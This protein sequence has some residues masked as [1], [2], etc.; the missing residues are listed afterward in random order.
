MFSPYQNL[1][2]DHHGEPHLSDDH[3][4]TCQLYQGQACSQYLTGQRVH[5][6]SND[7]ETIHKIDRIVLDASRVISNSS[8]VSVPCKRYAEKAFCFHN[9]EICDPQ[10]SA[11]VAKD[12]TVLKICKHDCS[13]VEKDLCPEEYSKARSQDLVGHG[14]LLPDCGEL[15]DHVTK[16]A[17]LLGDFDELP[18]DDPCYA[19]NGVGY[20]GTV[21]I[22]EHG[23]KCQRWIEVRKKFSEYSSSKYLELTDNNFCRNPG[24]EKTRPWCFTLDNQEEYCNI[25]KCPV[26]KT[27][28]HNSAKDSSSVTESVGENQSSSTGSISANSLAAILGIP[29]SYS[30]YLFTATGIL[31]FLLIIF[32]L[33]LLY[34]MF[35]K[36]CGPQKKGKKP[37]VGTSTGIGQQA[38]CFTTNGSI[39]K[40]HD[41]QL[42]MMHLI[43]GSTSHQPNNDP[44]MHIRQIPGSN[45]EIMETLG[46]GQYGIVKKGHL[47]GFQPDDD[48]IEPFYVALKILKEGAPNKQVTHDL[49]NFLTLRSSHFSVSLDSLEIKRINRDNQ[50][51][52]LHIATQIASGMEYLAANHY[53][54]R[55]L[56]ARNCLVADRITIKISDFGLARDVYANDYY[57]VQSSKRLPIRW[58]SPESI[59]QGNFS[60]AS[61]V[62]AFG[63]T[64]WEIYSYGLQPYLGRDNADI[65]TLVRQ[66]HLLERPDH[67]PSHIFGLMMECWMEKP[68]RRPTFVE[69]HQRLQT[70]SLTALSNSPA[71]STVGPLGAGGVGQNH[72]PQQLRTG[73]VLSGGSGSSRGGSGGAGGDHCFPSYGRASSTASVNN[74][75]QMLMNGVG[76]Y[77]HPPPPATPVSQTGAY[78]QIQNS[79]NRSTNNNSF[80]RQNNGYCN[81]MTNGSYGQASPN[82]IKKQ[83]YNCRAPHQQYAFHNASLQLK[84]SA[85]RGLSEDY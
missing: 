45:I 57:V 18:R 7:P 17:K 28:S 65:L 68:L 14:N 1:P 43:P 61:D 64:L 51:D 10:T 71:H 30:P 58:M 59:L 20:R 53:V 77:H 5:V 34:K 74:N 42:E 32:L 81:L 38:N 66:R 21:S 75:G 52:F 79:T 24:G 33:T 83:Y 37:A 36:S 56:A 27:S 4:G 47:I 35:K 73:S 22:T 39:R 13:V 15:P 46:E 48:D 55:D 11:D 3:P 25:A 85:P 82:M 62:W 16:C 29:A 8:E 19:G 9:F 12:A 63:V 50:I 2:I 69:L 76:A 54:H 78:H 72:W 40:P 44:L 23:K 67:C 41:Q 6:K 84:F 26:D 49:R 70:W 80:S 31:A 60:E